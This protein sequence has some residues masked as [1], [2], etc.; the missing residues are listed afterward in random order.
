MGQ[1]NVLSLRSVSA[2]TI[3]YVGHATLLIERDG[4]RILTDPVLRD[5]ILLLRRQGPPPDFEAIGEPDL[6]LVSHSH[7]DHLDVHSLAPGRRRLG[8]RRPPG[9]CRLRAARRRRRG[10][11][12]RTRASA[13]RPQ[14]SR[15]RLSTPSTQAPGRRFSKAHARPGLRAARIAEH[16]VRRRHRPLR[17][18]RGAAGPGRRRADPGRGLGARRWARATST[19]N[20]PREA[21]EL[22]QPK[23]AIPI[24]WGTLTAPIYRMPDLDEPRA[25]VREAGP[26]RRVRYRGRRARPRREHRA[27]AP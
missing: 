7:Y 5:R 17:R 6:V 9:L 19:P 18:A 10:D 1:C 4:K 8:G 14:A 3:T 16:L 27:P 23:V 24:H 22:I 2:T 13:P 26:R 15:W 20:G 25:R 21:V 11:R 12:A